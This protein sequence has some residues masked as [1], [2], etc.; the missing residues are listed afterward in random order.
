MARY[1]HGAWE[2]STSHVLLGA[3]LAGIV[4]CRLGFLLLSRQDKVGGRSQ[5]P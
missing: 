4:L 2:K 5:G 3:E 1:V